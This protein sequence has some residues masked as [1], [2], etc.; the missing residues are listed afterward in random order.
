MNSRTWRWRG[1]RSGVSVMIRPYHDHAFGANTCSKILLTPN[2]RSWFDGEQ[3]FEPPAR[4]ARSG[5]GRLGVSEASE[6]PAT[7]SGGH[8]DE[9]HTLVVRSPHLVNT[10]LGATRMAAVT[11][12]L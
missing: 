10:A 3:A 9:R 8:G 4:H 7:A 6:L 12:F 11:T 2:G 5:S 1:V